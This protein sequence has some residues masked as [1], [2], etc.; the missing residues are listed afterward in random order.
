MFRIKNILG[1]KF[2]KSFVC[3]FLG[4]RSLEYSGVLVDLVGEFVFLFFYLEGRWFLY[5]FWK[6]IF[7]EGGSKRLGMVV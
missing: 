6:E 4:D 2:L 5:F 1:S 7:R 3:G